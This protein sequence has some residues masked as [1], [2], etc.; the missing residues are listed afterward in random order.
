[1]LGHC[2]TA[3]HPIAGVHVVD[4]IDHMDGRMMD[5]TADHALGASLARCGG[6]LL[7]EISSVADGSFYPVFEEGGERPIGKAKPAP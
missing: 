5:V 2:G 6:K 1:M 4:P 3:F 7:L